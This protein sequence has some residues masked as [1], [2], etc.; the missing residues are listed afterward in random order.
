MLDLDE[1]LCV[2]VAKRSPFRAL[3]TFNA[4][5][6]NLFFFT[7]P[8]AKQIRAKRFTQD[9]IDRLGRRV[10]ELVLPI[11]KASEH[12]EVVTNIRIEVK[13]SISVRHELGRHR[14]QN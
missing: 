10:F 12:R 4:M 6:R 2:D 13:S 11:P 1:G 3:V 5:L 14:L 7:T 8:V 9:I